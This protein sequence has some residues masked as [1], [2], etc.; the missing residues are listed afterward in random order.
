MYYDNLQQIEGIEIQRF[1][2][3]NVDSTFKDLSIIIK[4]E[5][6]GFNRDELADILNALGIPTKKYFYPPIHKML[7]YK[8]YNDI[9]LPNT[10]FISENVLSLPIYAELED[11]TII[12]IVEIIK[13]NKEDY[14]QYIN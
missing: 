3:E 1:S 8:E 14:I 5:I 7:A 9:Y 11:E 10:E 13:D 4:K 12:D 6:Y 2:K